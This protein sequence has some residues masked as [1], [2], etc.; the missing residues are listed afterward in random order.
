M[1]VQVKSEIVK[2]PHEEDNK[3]GSSAKMARWSQ[4]YD[5]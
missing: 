2:P 3:G 1:R 4:F 5:K